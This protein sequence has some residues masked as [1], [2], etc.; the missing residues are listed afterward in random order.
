M[1]Q[2]MTAR[3]HTTSTIL[4]LPGFLAKVGVE[5]ERDGCAQE[6]VGR[7]NAGI[8][9]QSKHNQDED[10]NESDPDDEKEAHAIIRIGMW[11]WLMIARSFSFVFRGRYTR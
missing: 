5:Y 8:A 4:S 6:R 7:E 9:G 2:F 3:A 1:N 10:G 11:R